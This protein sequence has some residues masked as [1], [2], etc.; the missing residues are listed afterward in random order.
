MEIKPDPMCLPED[1]QLIQFQ[2]AV[3]EL[4]GK[5]REG[6]YNA[7]EEAIYERT[8]GEVG[9]ETVIVHCIL[10]EV[11]RWIPIDEPGPFTGEMC[12]LPK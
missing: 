4:Y 9:E 6:Y 12:L 3:E 7:I 8:E 5:W 11:S 10:A 2:I 1:K